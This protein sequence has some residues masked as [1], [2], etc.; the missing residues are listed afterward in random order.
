MILISTLKKNQLFKNLILENSLRLGK[1]PKFTNKKLTQYL[2]GTKNNLEIFRV[3]ELQY[4]LLRIY[5]FVR[6]LFRN[7]RIN[8]ITLKKWLKKR[9]KVPTWAIKSI[10][11][12]TTPSHL[13]YHRNNIQK[14]YWRDAKYTNSFL[15]IPPVQILFAT[16]TFAY[17]N[18]ITSAARMCH[19]PFHKGRWLSGSITARA[20]YVTDIE[21]WRPLLNSNIRSV[22][23]HFKKKYFITKEQLSHMQGLKIQWKETRQPSLIIIPDVAKSLMIVEESKKVG[24]PVLGL[25]NSDQICLIDYP[26][27]GNSD[28]IYLVHFFCHFLSI[29][30]SKQII[31]RRHTWTKNVIKNQCFVPQNNIKKKRSVIIPGLDKNYSFFFCKN[32]KIENIKSFKTPFKKSWTNKNGNSW[33]KKG[34]KERDFNKILFKQYTMSLGKIYLGYNNKNSVLQSEFLNYMT[35]KKTQLWKIWSLF[36][37]LT[38][39]Q[40]INFAKHTKFLYLFL[41]QNML[42][43]KKTWTLPIKNVIVTEHRHTKNFFKESLTLIP[44]Q[45]NSSNYILRFKK[46]Q[47]YKFLHL[48]FYNMLQKK[49]NRRLYA[50]SNSSYYWWTLNI[51][52]NSIY[53]MKSSL[54]M[55]TL[56]EQ[57]IF[58]QRLAAWTL[59]RN[60]YKGHFKWRKHDKKRKKLQIPSK[61]GS[62]EIKK[63]TT[64]SK[65]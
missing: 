22:I 42:K 19:M 9:S 41:M 10:S 4:I 64:T 28:S 49:K 63:N 5:P 13:H 46:Q 16:T 1:N 57:K 24:L 56:F 30:I 45:Q 18:I 36:S 50:R 44:L 53:I 65:R 52:S 43:L 21:F 14:K 55:N 20:S 54:W 39:T 60:K 34:R 61:K 62:S 47:F 27:I 8:Y 11:K 25:I 33:S 48:K 51:L 58:Q 2:H 35:R 3:S 7:H 38:F 29:M 32:S 12:E 40:E 59:R 26:L 23:K 6:S 17:A 31:N 15:K 37:K